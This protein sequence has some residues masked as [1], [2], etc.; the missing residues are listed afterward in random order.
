MDTETQE[1]DFKVFEAPSGERLDIALATLLD[2]SRSFA[3]YLIVGGYVQLDGKPTEKPAYKLHGTEIITVFMPPPRMPAVVAEDIDLEIVYEDDDMAVINK[4]PQ[5]IAHPTASIRTGTVVNALMGRIALAKEKSSNPAD[6]EY[7][8]G[9]V[10]RLDKDTSGV[11]VIAKHDEAHRNISAAF[12]QRIT[13][14]EY[15]A[16]GIGKMDEEVHVNAPIGRNVHHAYKMAVGGHTPKE[17]S[18]RFHLLATAK[19]PQL[20]QLSLVRAKPRTGRTHQIRVHMLQIGVPI[21]GDELYGRASTT[22]P[23]QA[24]H[25][26]GLTLPHPRDKQPVSFNAPIPMDMIEAWLKVGGTWPAELLQS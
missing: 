25:A 8:P 3:K 20:G 5:L 13:Q 6:E 23:R 1:L 16:I 9:I 24:L 18:T 2:E 12:K 15:I 10:H 21:W 7:R 11:M 4:P 17:A 19:H 14:K 22:M 26:F